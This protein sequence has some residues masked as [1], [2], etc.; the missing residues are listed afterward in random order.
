MDACFE[1]VELQRL[2]GIGHFVP[3]EAPE[4]VAQQ[5][6]RFWQAQGLA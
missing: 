6:H 3:E 5:L 2:P 4:T 1:Q